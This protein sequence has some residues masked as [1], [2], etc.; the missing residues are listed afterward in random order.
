MHLT[1]SVVSKMQECRIRLPQ[2]G[3]R[4]WKEFLFSWW[5]VFE[6]FIVSK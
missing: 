5:A 4:R 6:N 2:G 1:S 3:H